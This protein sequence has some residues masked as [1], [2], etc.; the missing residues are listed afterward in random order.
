MVISKA[1]VSN[2]DFQSNHNGIETVLLF[3]TRGYRKASNRTIMELKHATFKPFNFY[4]CLP[5]EP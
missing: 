3:L 2:V 1:I 4:G 5:I